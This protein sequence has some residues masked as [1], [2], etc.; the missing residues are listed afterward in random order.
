MIDTPIAGM[1]ASTTTIPDAFQARAAAI[2]VATP[3]EGARFQKKAARRAGVIAGS[4]SMYARIIH[5]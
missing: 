1:T 2:E 5:K 4:A 3:A